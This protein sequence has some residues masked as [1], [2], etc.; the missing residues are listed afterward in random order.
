M[1][2]CENISDASVQNGPDSVPSL[3]SDVDDTKDIGDAGTYKDTT[4]SVQSRKSSVSNDTT[5]SHAKAE[6][7]VNPT[8]RSDAR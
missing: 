1:S 7:L 3:R 8:A 6:N 2:D 4:E 5:K